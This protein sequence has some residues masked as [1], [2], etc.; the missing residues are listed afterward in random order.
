MTTT[1]VTLKSKELVTIM[2]EVFIASLKKTGYPLWL[3]YECSSRE[4][5]QTVID[6]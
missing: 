4:D 6:R 2:S 1:Q 5:T 3:V